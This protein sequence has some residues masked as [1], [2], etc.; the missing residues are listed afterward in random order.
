LMRAAVQNCFAQTRPD[1]AAA[2]ACRKQGKD[3][4][5]FGQELNDFV[6]GC[7]AGKL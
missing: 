7:K 6:K 2:N 3:K 4:G 1:L 5:L